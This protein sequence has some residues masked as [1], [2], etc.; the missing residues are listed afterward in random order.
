MAS[1]EAREVLAAL[2]ALREGD[3]I[4]FRVPPKLHQFVD[5]NGDKV[6]RKV[7]GYSGWGHVCAVDERSNTVD[8]TRLGEGKTMVNHCTVGMDQIERV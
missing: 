2:S 7:P 6:T 8:V 4:Y 1:A 5:R 3:L